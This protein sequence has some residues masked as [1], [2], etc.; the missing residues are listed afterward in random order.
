MLCLMGLN[1]IWNRFL[2]NRAAVAFAVAPYRKLVAQSFARYGIE[3]ME[4]L[5]QITGF[6]FSSGTLVDD[7]L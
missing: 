5:S 6:M 2:V 1:S 7:F 4:Q 3:G